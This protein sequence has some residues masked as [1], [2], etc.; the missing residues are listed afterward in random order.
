M[1]KNLSQCTL[2][3]L[4]KYDAT[5]AIVKH[6][7]KYWDA[8]V[9][10]KGYAEYKLN[11]QDYQDMD[12]TIASVEDFDG[13]VDDLTRGLPISTSLSLPHVAYDDTNQ[14]RDPLTVLI[15][16]CIAYGRNLQAREDA[17]NHQKDV[18]MYTTIIKLLSEK[19]EKM[20]GN[21]DD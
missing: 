11:Y 20:T 14:G 19:I 8:S 4:Q 2:K 3:H 6:V 15:G 9:A 17:F 7:R 21:K 1:K 13:I 12:E 5:S 16:S 10:P 18:E